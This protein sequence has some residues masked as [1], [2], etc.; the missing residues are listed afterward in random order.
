MNDGKGKLTGGQNT[1][2][3]AWQ[4][5]GGRITKTMTKAGVR[6]VKARTIST[7]DQ[8]YHPDFQRG[9]TARLKWIPNIS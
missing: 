2:I 1:E 4:R 7:G 5:T 6:I 8:N 3:K 9:I